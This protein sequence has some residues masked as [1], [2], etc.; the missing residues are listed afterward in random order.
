MYAGNSIKL[1]MRKLPAFYRVQLNVLMHARRSYVL[2]TTF[3]HGSEASTSRTRFTY[4]L[5]PLQFFA[6]TKWL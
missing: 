6:A 4:D 3:F 2:V 5:L 1:K